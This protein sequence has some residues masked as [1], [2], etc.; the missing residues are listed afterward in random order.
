MLKEIW[1]GNGENGYFNSISHWKWW[2][3]CTKGSFP[4][5][6]RRL[7]STLLYFVGLFSIRTEYLLMRVVP[8]TRKS[9]DTICMQHKKMQQQM[10]S[11]WCSIFF[12]VTAFMTH[13]FMNAHHWLVTDWPIS[14]MQY[15]DVTFSDQLSLLAE[16]VPKKYLLPGSTS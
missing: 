13:W 6:L 12:E 8:Y 14:G 5:V 9:C 1:K 11:R 15:V 10:T 16:Q 7:I 4:L 2:Y 3:Q